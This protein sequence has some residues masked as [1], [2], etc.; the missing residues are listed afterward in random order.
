M[1]NVIK[2][3]NIKTKYTSG[4]TDVGPTCSVGCGV[5]YCVYAAC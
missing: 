3:N 1:K 5:I 4:C 2:L